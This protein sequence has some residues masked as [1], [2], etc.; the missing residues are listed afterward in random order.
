ME[1]TLYYS[2]EYLSKS[3]ELIHRYIILR[4]IS[5]FKS[6]ES[7]T[8]ISKESRFDFLDGYRGS[9]AFTV[10]VIHSRIH[11][12][13]EIVN[14]FYGFSQ[15]YAIAGFFML[16]AFLLTYR[17]LA[18]FSKTSDPFQFLLYTVKF[19]IRRF[20]RVYLYYILFYMVAK[21]SPDWWF[22]YPRWSFSKSLKDIALLGNAGASHLWTIPAELKYY[23]FIPVFCLFTRLLKR[24]QPIFLILC[25]SWSAWDQVYNFFDLKTDDTAGQT[26]NTHFLKSHFAVFFLGSQVALAYHIV[27]RNQSIMRF[28]KLKWVQIILDYGS[29]FIAL[30]GLKLNIY[31]WYNSYTFKSRATIFWSI[32]LFLTL[33]SRPNMISKFFSSNQFLKNFG[34]Y[35]YSFY[36]IHGGIGNF[37]RYSCLY[38]YQFEFILI[39]IVADYYASMLLFNL[40]ENNLIKLANYVC[41]KID[42]NWCCKR[43]EEPPLNM[44]SDNKKIIDLKPFTSVDLFKS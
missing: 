10:L 7:V 32:S 41:E 38:K 6:C 31:V 1:K 28:I 23:L 2:K 27:E 13:C 16:S 35:S 21:N 5:I 42:S 3:I 24:F 25:V 22:G 8:T 29:L 34:R 17:L 39:C 44:E 36:L 20:F 4:V 14:I 15:S 33:L 43:K 40:I 11:E 19:F 12:N 18:E 30:T 26:P 37:F 9:L